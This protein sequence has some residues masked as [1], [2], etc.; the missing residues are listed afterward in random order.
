MTYQ[1]INRYEQ[2]EKKKE[3]KKKR[4]MLHHKNNY[5]CLTSCPNNGVH[6]TF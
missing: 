4:E 3:A 2:R 6:Y 1:Q 5:I